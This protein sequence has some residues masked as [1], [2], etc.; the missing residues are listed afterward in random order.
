MK[1]LSCSSEKIFIDDLKTMINISFNP[2]FDICQKTTL[3]D[4]ERKMLDDLSSR[5]ISIGDLKTSVAVMCRILKRYYGKD[6]IV[7]ID[8]YDR[9]VTD[10]FGKD[11]QP[12]ILTILG[13]FLSSTLKS[14]NALQMAY[15]TGVMDVA[16]TGIFSGLNNISVNDVFSTSSD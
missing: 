14:N 8:E 2:F 13:E 16:R 1:S 6:V 4:Y 7:L 10:S 11:V 12:A 5:T 9:A 3:T 15:I